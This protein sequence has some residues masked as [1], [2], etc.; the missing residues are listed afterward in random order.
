MENSNVSDYQ[1]ICN[2]AHDKSIA[3]RNQSSLCTHVHDHHA[4][5]VQQMH[6]AYPL[7]DLILCVCEYQE[8]Q[9]PGQELHNKGCS[10]VKRAVTEAVRLCI[11]L[12]DTLSPN[13]VTLTLKHCGLSIIFSA[14]QW[15][16]QKS[17]ARRT[18]LLLSCMVIWLESTAEQKQPVRRAK[19]GVR[20][21]KSVA[22]ETV[23]AARRHREKT[24][25]L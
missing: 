5:D 16:Q 1:G 22:K 3:L 4:P 2:P 11:L 19:R 13:L 14:L 8:S 17:G 25:E 10:M 15:K 18:G 7:T 9:W 20:K 12:D 6:K 23:P 24:E 21:R